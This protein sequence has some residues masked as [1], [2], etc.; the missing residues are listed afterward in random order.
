MTKI[1]Q[2]GLKAFLIHRK[3]AF[4]SA[5]TVEQI[6]FLLSSLLLECFWVF[7]FIGYET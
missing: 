6:F 1:L 4:M 7:A 2:F 3:F 5:F